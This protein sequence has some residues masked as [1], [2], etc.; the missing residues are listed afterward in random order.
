MSNRDDIPLG[1]TYDAN[2]NELSYKDSDG[3]WHECTYDAHGNESSYKNSSGYWRE[4]TYDA[5]GNELSS[6]HSSGEWREYT[7]D[8][9]R[10]VLAYRNILRFGGALMHSRAVDDEYT[11]FVSDDGQ[12]CAGCRGFDTVAEALA[13][14]NRADKRAVLFTSALKAISI[15]NKKI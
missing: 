6:K 12:V 4:F 8:A 5:H 13:H 10:R 3:Y 7:Y 11:L 14:W 9:E 1:I 15:D 2:E